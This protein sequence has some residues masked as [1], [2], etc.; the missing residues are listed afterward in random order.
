MQAQSSD[1][2]KTQTKEFTKE[3]FGSVTPQAEK[4]EEKLVEAVSKPKT[5][6]DDKVKRMASDILDIPEF[7]R[8]RK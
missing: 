4:K 3:F 2:Q 6:V 5:I 1:K 8:G 7:L